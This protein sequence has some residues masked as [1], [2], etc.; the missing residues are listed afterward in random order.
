MTEEMEVFFVWDWCAADLQAGR[1]WAGGGGRKEGGM[2]LAGTVSFSVNGDISQSW[3]TARLLVLSKYFNDVLVMLG[4]F[5]E[6]LRMF[7]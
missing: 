7:Y 5:V 3:C 1:G 4:C 6:V 2:L